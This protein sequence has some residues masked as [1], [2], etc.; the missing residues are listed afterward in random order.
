LSI[1]EKVSK[2]T[3][4]VLPDFFLDRIVLVPSFRNL[5]QQVA[6]KAA[7]GGG[8]VRGVVQTEVLG[9]NAANLAYAL[10]SL[11]ARTNLYC[12]GN[13]LA[14][15]ALSRHPARCKVRI[16]PGEPGYTTALEFT[17]KGRPV[18]V[19]LSN[20]GD[21]S[22]FN[23]DVFT[24]TD[25]EALKKSD[26]IALVNWS[27]NLKGNELAGTV[28]NLPGRE[29]RLTFL[30]PADVAGAESRIKG[31]IKSVVE[32]GALDV[33]SL[34]ENEAR[35][36][37]N[38]L[39]VGKLPYSYRLKDLVR[40]SSALHD[41]LDIAVDIHTPIGSASSTVRGQACAES[42]GKAAGFVTGA[43]DVWDAGD[44]IG[45]LLKFNDEDRLRFASACAHLYVAVEEN[46]LPTL[47]EV[48]SFLIRKRHQLQ[49]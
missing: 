27:A 45:H 12:V 24:H 8:S 43:G 19:M 5:F 42:Y 29:R 35:I 34:N 9:G 15:A 14:Q 20:I 26:C 21:V 4:S 25:I 2:L 38:L 36:I 32:E 49:G 33:M 40:V 18:N 41:R 10:S 37:A 7:S 46:R 16:I 17:F 3:V 39:S 13:A 1:R 30:D 11:S 28:F 47:R 48:S 31:L 6:S 23:G 22:S 44:I